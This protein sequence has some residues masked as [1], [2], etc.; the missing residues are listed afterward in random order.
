MATIQEPQARLEQLEPDIKRLARRWCRDRP[1]AAEDL[2]QV[3]R[4]AM[5][6][7]LKERPDAPVSHLMCKAKEDILDERKRGHSVDGRLDPVTRRSFRW[8]IESLDAPRLDGQEPLADALESGPVHAHNPWESPVE[9][10]A[11][12]RVLYHTLRED[13]TPREDALLTLLLI[14]YGPKGAGALLELT[15][16]QA[17]RSQQAIQRKAIAVLGLEYPGLFAPT[18]TTPKQRAAQTAARARWAQRAPFTIPALVQELLAHALD[19]GQ[20]G[21]W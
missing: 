18:P 20:E 13:L 8:L 4:L 2:A 19:D 12:G 3:A 14:G 1:A 6:L 15:K 9:A 5:W 16:Q 7:M 10:E 11:V 21:T 17:F